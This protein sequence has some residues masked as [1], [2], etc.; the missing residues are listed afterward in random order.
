MLC[1]YIVYL[2]FQTSEKS[3]G[4]HPESVI[5]AFSGQLLERR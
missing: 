5:L 4:S 3:R 1:P 2:H